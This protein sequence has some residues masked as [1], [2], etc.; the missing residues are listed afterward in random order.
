M[1]DKKDMGGHTGHGDTKM[2]NRGDVQDTR[3]RDLWDKKDMGGTRVIGD[4][5]N[6]ERGGVQGWEGAGAREGAQVTWRT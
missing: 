4:T 3:C 5:K 6:G 1:G 2:G